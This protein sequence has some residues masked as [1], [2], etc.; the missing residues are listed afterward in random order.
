MRPLLKDDKLCKYMN[1]SFVSPALTDCRPPGLSLS[2]GGLQA[3]SWPSADPH[4]RLRALPSPSSLPGS[5]FDKPDWP[6]HAWGRKLGPDIAVC[7]GW[8][9]RLLP[10]H[11]GL[12]AHLPA[13][14]AQATAPFFPPG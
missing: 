9:P 8:V 5:S 13:G 11:H 6:R 1:K 4:C 10:R 12:R 14:S 2:V 7:P 3:L